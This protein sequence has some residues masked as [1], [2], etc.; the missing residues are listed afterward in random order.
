MEKFLRAFWGAASQIIA[1]SLAQIQLFYVP[2]INSLLFPSTVCYSLWSPAVLGW[3]QAT[4]K[5]PSCLHCLFLTSGSLKAAEIILA[6]LC[7]W[8]PGQS[9]G[10]PTR[11][12]DSGTK[13]R[14]RCALVISSSPGT[15]AK[16]VM[17]FFPDFFCG[18]GFCDIL[19]SLVYPREMQGGSLM[20][21][22]QLMN[23]WGLCLR[24]GSTFPFPWAFKS[25]RQPDLRARTLPL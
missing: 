25:V 12:L 21:T 1:L 7:P 14:R 5:Q 9:Q 24:S 23:I 11:S 19:F 4:L 17:R 22:F 8:N 2:I 10:P 13:P 18:K 20:Q 6:C 3:H 16:I 15:K